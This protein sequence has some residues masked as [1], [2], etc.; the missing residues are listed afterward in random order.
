MNNKSQ[1]LQKLKIDQ[2]Y[3]LYVG[4]AYPHKNLERLIDAFEIISKQENIK[5]VLVGKIDYFYNRLRK[6]IIDRGL[7]DKIILTD[8]ISDEDLD[9]LYKNA[10]LFVFPSLMEGFGLPGLEAMR[11]GLP[12]ACSKIEV[13][14]E[15]YGQAAQYFKPLDISDM[16]KII[17]DL[18]K[19]PI[20]KE[21]L[22]KKGLE[23]VEKYSWEKC[24]KETLD[25]YQ[26]LN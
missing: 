24:A 1:I 23:Q 15:I 11:R 18:I 10:S 21:N 7:E 19:N 4:N 8:V 14:S 20:F 16:A 2:S 17:L 22:T 13:F 26:S 5:L 12:V 9:C 3:L 6:I 25:I